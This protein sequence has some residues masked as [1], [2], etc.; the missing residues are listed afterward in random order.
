MWLSISKYNSILYLWIFLIILTVY[1]PHNQV[2]LLFS[3]WVALREQF[4]ACGEQCI[5]RRWTCTNNLGRKC[6]QTDQ[7][8]WPEYLFWPNLHNIIIVVLLSPWTSLVSWTWNIPVSHT[9]FQ[10]FSLVK[11]IS[12]IAWGWI[13]LFPYFYRTHSNWCENVFQWGK[14][15]VRE[16]GSKCASVYAHYACASL[17]EAQNVPVGKCEDERRAEPT[18]SERER[19]NGFYWLLTPKTIILENACACVCVCWWKVLISA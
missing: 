10:Y 8:C 15:E 17:S 18:T 11:R 13:C 5:P 4:P 3:L 1:I 19:T 12:I 16:G 14:E 7:Y 9:F 6:I 2:S